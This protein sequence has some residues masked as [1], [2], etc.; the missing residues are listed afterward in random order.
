[1]WRTVGISLDVYLT[2][3]WKRLGVK[4]EEILV[5]LLISVAVEISITAFFF[6]AIIQSLQIHVIRREAMVATFGSD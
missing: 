5:F 1:M 4:H 2:R 3:V 6:G